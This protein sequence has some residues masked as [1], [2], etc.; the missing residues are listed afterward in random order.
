MKSF[1]TISNSLRSVLIARHHFVFI[2]CSRRLRPYQS[3]S[4]SIQMTVVNGILTKIGILK[5]SLFFYFFHCVLLFHFVLKISYVKDMNLDSNE[6]LISL[7]PSWVSSGVK[8]IGGCCRID[9]H[10]IAKFNEFITQS[11]SVK[12]TN[13]IWTI[14]LFFLLFLLDLFSFWFSKLE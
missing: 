12:S 6:L 8:F 14:W 4:L 1:A 13:K 10:A 2:T 11:S 3:R 5:L 7:I 9:S